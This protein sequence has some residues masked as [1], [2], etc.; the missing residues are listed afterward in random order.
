[1]RVVGADEQRLAA[2]FDLVFA[3]GRARADE[4][5]HGVGR[6]GRDQA[7]LAGDVVGSA[8]DD[9]AAVL[10]GVDA[11]EEAR[12][13]LLIQQGVAA[14]GAEPVQ[15]DAPRPPFVI[16]LGPRQRGAVGGPDGCAEAVRGDDR[17][18]LAGRKIADAQ[19]EALRTIGVDCV[20]ELRPVGADR[21]TAETEIVEVAGESGFVED[22]LLAA[23]GR[24]TQ[25]DAVLAAG[26][27]LPPIFI[28][29][30]ADGDARVVLLHPA[31]QFL[32]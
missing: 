24:A 7:D 4:Q 14:G 2:H 5:R 11:D 9:L 17:A 19:R 12:I 3:A 1:M 25:P 23:T 10:A 26:G 22:D 30:V 31:L 27:E 29:T 13:A 21:L 16:D 15:A 28:R 32:V 8:D 18:V 6:G 20:S